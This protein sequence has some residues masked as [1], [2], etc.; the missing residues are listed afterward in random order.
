MTLWEPSLFEARR[1]ERDAFLSRRE[2][3]AWRGLQVLFLAFGAAIL[4]S[5]AFLPEL[6]LDLL[7]N[8][9]IP[10]APA[11]L[12]L[13]PGL[14]RNVCPIAVTVLA[15]RTLGLSLEIRPSPRARSSLRVLGFL[16]LLGIVPL[17]HARLDLDAGAS[18]VV[19]LV[20]VGAGFMLGLFFDWKSAWCAGLC[21]VHPVEELYGDRPLYA[22]KNAHCR[23]CALCVERCPDCIPTERPNHRRSLRLSSAL[24]SFWMPALFPGFIYGWFQVPDYLPGEGLDLWSA[25]YLPPL[26]GAAGSLLLFTLCRRLLPESRGALLRRTFAFLAVACYYWFR[27][28]ALFGFG[29]FPGDGMLLDL[30][31][32]L[33]PSFEWF[34][35]LLT[36]SFFAWWMFRPGVRGRPWLRRP[37]VAD[38]AAGR[39]P[40]SDAD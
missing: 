9:L 24:A 7:W 3:L 21:P 20:L 35:R 6:G 2:R 31:G 32:S 39:I 26:G 17:R 25:I 16:L 8:V 37:P 19:L 14:W 10:A 23:A 1:T 36:T 30:R 40:L 29:P 11:L 15:P 22:P 33:P 38:E 28:P 34:L 5:L 4:L 12:V 13:A 18:F 27:L